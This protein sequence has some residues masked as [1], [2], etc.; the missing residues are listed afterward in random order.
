MKV[1]IGDGYP[2]A[3]LGLEK[4]VATFGD[5]VEVVEAGSFSECLDAMRQEDGLKLALVDMNM[6]DMPWEQGL[7]RLREAG[8]GTPIIAMAPNG[9]RA[10]VFRMIELGASGFVPRTASEEQLSKAINLVLSG[11]V[12]LPRSVIETNERQETPK[13]NGEAAHETISENAMPML[14][15]RQRE[16]LK[17]LAEGKRNSEIAEILGTSEFTVRVHVSAIL[18]GL[19][20]ANRTQAALKAKDILR[21]S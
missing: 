11:A 17:W 5:G 20:V 4:V 7:R 12:Y 1:L 9:V 15:R 3:R 2:V 21:D 16:V 18:K 10:D 19:G 6:T 14:T 13:G 8:N